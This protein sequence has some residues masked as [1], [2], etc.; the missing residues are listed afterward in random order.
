MTLTRIPYKTRFQSHLEAIQ[1]FLE[2][3]LVT[4][5]PEQLWAAMRHGVLNGGKRIR[6]VLLMETCLACGGT[7]ANALA[8]AAALELIH[9]YSLIHDDLPCM[10]NDDFR[11]GQPTVHKAFS[12]DLAV[13]AG[14][15]LVGM[16][17]GLIPDRTQGVPDK[18][19]LQVISELSQAASVKGLVN[20][21]VDDILFATEIPTEERLYRIHAGKT[22]ALF[23]F[24]TWAGGML[25]GQSEE[26]VN[27]LA[28]YGNTLGI[29]FQI[30]DDLLDVESTGDVLGK[31]PGK[32]A[33]QGK[34]TF[35]A[36][37]GIEG[38]KNVLQTHVDALNEIL[39]NLSKTIQTENLRF[40][41]QFVEERES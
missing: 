7:M 40:L 14:D 24:A 21:Q 31:T 9:C 33:A 30:V 15:A 28:Q 13:L 39:D 4:R 5:E 34:I 29:A 17:F 20:G 6:P 11:R 38:S 19:L 23:R 26:V 8:T 3:I 41:V 22:G 2:N 35:P 36:V 12:E 16:A 25:A 32:D 27:Q 37:Y 10:D 18:V 1:Q